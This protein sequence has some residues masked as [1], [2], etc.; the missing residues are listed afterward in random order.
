MTPIW[1]QVIVDQ[2]GIYT[3]LIYHA[4]MSSKES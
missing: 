3:E 4:L 2:G 1:L